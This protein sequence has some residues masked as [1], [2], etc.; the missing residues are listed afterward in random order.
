MSVLYFFLFF[1]F[2]LLIRNFIF[3]KY[4]IYPKTN[5]KGTLSTII[6]EDVVREIV[7]KKFTETPSD[8]G[9]IGNS[10]ILDAINPSIITKETKLSCFN[11]AHYYISFSNSLR[12]L[13]DS[14]CYPK[15]MFV[16]VSTRYSMFSEHY[17]RADYKSKPGPAKA[18]L[19][20]LSNKISFL[21]PS[22]FVPSPYVNFLYRGIKKIKEARKRNLPVFSRYSPFSAFVSYQ[23]SLNITTNH[24]IANTFRK[25]RLQERLSETKNLRKAIQVTPSLCDQHH[26]MYKK[27]MQIL[28]EFLIKAS[29]AK[30]KVVFMR[31]PL[32]QRLIFFENKHCPYFFEDIKRKLARYEYN[33]IDLNIPFNKENP[34]NFY[35]DGQHLTEDSSVKVSTYLATYINTQL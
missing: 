9:F 3:T 6:E 32:D 5:Y 12:V 21:F 17:A 10:H 26:E 34:L 31:L 15:I 14:N 4:Y 27:S 29:Q 16:D 2:Y 20:K 33:F 11:Y 8:I 35:S 24:R 28:D 23:W 1:F 19:R 7:A 13:M 25:K 18:F 22:L 30:S